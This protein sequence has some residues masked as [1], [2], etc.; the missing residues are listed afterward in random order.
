VNYGQHVA[1]M[2]LH[3]GKLPTDL[4][5]ELVQEYFYTSKRF[6]TPSQT[7]FKHC[8]YGLK[9]LLKSEGLPCEYLHLPSIKHDK[10]LPTVLKRRSFRLLHHCQLLKHKILIGLLYGCGSCCMKCEVYACKMLILTVNNSK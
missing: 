4:N 1:S 10:K 8:V 7:Y 3:F 9:F 5:V 6:K 2:A